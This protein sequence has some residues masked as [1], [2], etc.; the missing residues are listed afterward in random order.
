MQKGLHA[1]KTL[2]LSKQR[3]LPVDVWDAPLGTFP[4]TPGSGCP[5]NSGLCAS[6]HISA[7]YIILCTGTFVGPSVYGIIFNENTRSHIKYLTEGEVQIEGKKAKVCSLPPHF[8]S[9]K[10]THKCSVFNCSRLCSE[11]HLYFNFLRPL[12]SYRQL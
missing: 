5:L 3:G 8:L 2:R 11:M 1:V 6:L 9:K 12:P 4:L 10:T 7:C